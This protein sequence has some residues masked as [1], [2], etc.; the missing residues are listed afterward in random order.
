MKRLLKRLF[1]RRVWVIRGRNA[2]YSSL[3]YEVEN[4]FICI[5]KGENKGFVVDMLK[6]C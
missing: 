4:G 5:K 1:R 3:W 6:D 2:G